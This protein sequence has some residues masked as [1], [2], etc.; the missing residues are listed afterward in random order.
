METKGVLLNLREKHG[1]T[2]DEMAG[3][4][5]V[6]REFSISINTLLGS[7]QSLICQCC[8]M[9]LTDEDISRETD[10]FFNEEYCKWCYT[11]GEMVYKSLD[12]LMA[13]LVPHLSGLHHKKEDDIRRML[14]TQLPYLN[15]WKKE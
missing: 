8:G 1:L 3:R 11:D 13:F 10:G 15:L 6:S 2:Q 7:P 9:P 4:L 14:E 12:E 5:F